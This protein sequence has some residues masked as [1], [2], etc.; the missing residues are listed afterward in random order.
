VYN[1][2]LT[3]SAIFWYSRPGHRGNGIRLFNAFENWALQIGA[4]RLS[5]GHL[6]RLL[7]NKFEK[8]YRR[9]GYELNELHYTKIL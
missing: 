1:K 8:F 3:A 4:K 6:A 9:R 7:P 5:V 2:A